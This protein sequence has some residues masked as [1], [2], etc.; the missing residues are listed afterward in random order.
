MKQLK[1]QNTQIC[2]LI[3]FCRLIC[4]VKETII[5]LLRQSETTFIYEISV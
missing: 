1:G 4:Q 3:H 5:S 2:I